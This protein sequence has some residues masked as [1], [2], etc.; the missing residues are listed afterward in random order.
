MK[1]HEKVPITSARQIDCAIVAFTLIELLVVIAI[2]GILASL[3][4]P[5][6]SRAKSS[7]Y[8]IQCKSNLRQMILGLHMYVAEERFY[9][10]FYRLDGSLSVTNWIEMTIPYLGGPGAVEPLLRCPGDRG[11]GGFTS[12]GYNFAGSR[13]I[14][15][16]GERPAYGLGL[17]GWRNLQTGRI[18]PTPESGVRAPSQMI[19]LADGFHSVNWKTIHSSGWIGVNL[20]GGSPGADEE[21]AAR[22]RHGG[23]LNTAFCDGHVEAFAPRRLLLN[24]GEEML[25]RWNNNNDSG[26]DRLFFPSSSSF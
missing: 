1:T 20:L 8:S 10:H 2:I 16:S 22:R 23:H 9:P 15:L 21:S 24:S 25:R 26:P 6:L 11:A 3:L 4:L 12:Y 5:V 17:G 7:A 13:P 18:T 14:W 19:A